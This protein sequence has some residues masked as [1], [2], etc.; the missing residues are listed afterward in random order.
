ML[1]S[2][3]QPDIS[4]AKWVYSEQ[5]RIAIWDMQSSGD[6]GASPE[7]TGERKALPQREGVVQGGFGKQGPLEEAGGWKRSGFLL[8]EL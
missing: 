8:A 6:L 3:K 1:I 4:L 5:Q 7:N 2:N